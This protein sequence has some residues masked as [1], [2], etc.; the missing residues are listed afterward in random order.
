M[1][2]KFSPNAVIFYTFLY[3]L[4]NFVGALIIYHVSFF[5]LKL[6]F[7]SKFTTSKLRSQNLYFQYYLVKENLDI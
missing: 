6:V 4:S 1:L 3:I 2:G 5:L 7:Y